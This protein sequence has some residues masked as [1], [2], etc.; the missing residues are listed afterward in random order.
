MRRSKTPKAPSNRNL[1]S[2]LAVEL[3]IKVLKN[4]R[5]LPTL[6]NLLVASP[7]DPT[8]FRQYFYEIWGSVLRDEANE[9]HTSISAI[10]C[11]RLSFAPDSTFIAGELHAYISRRGW[12]TLA[13][14]RGDD[15]VAILLFLAEC[16]D[17]VN[18]L[19]TD[20]ARRRVLTPSGAPAGHLSHVEMYRIRRAFWRFCAL[21][22]RQIAKERSG[23]G[24]T[25]HKNP[26]FVS[27][28]V[29]GRY[30]PGN[31]WLFTTG[32]WN[33]DWSRFHDLMCSKMNGWEMDELNAVRGF[34]R[35]EVNSIQLDRIQ[36]SCMLPDQALLTQRLIKDLGDLPQQSNASSSL[37]AIA[38]FSHILAMNP[39]GAQPAIR[40]LHEWS[41]H[42]RCVELLN[43]TIDH[44]I[45][46]RFD[47]D[48]ERVRQKASQEAILE[49]QKDFIKW[50]RTKDPTLYEDWMTGRLPPVDPKTGAPRASLNRVS[51]TSADWLPINGCDEIVTGGESG[52][53]VHFA[54]ISA[55]G[56]TDD[57]L[58]HDDGAVDVWIN[59]AFRTTLNKVDEE[60]S[61]TTCSTVTTSAYD[62]ICVVIGPDCYS[63]CKID[64]TEVRIYT[65]Y[66]TTEPDGSNDLEAA[67]KEA[68]PGA[69]IEAWK[70]FESNQKY[71][72]DGKEKTEWE[73]T[74]CFDFNMQ[75]RRPAQLSCVQRG[76]EEAEALEDMPACEFVPLLNFESP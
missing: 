66:I 75:L 18:M 39:G 24:Q 63:S 70:S 52:A 47:A 21:C 68:C 22:Q 58:V 32:R 42:K 7:A 36:S 5:D 51:L 50:T 57:L 6:R 53:G 20:F 8:I 61:T 30:D 26:R 54:D 2:S 33:W 38:R 17:T 49:Y 62:T 43:T 74:Q 76:V 27:S 4:I 19:V 44:R 11:H 25:I 56:H 37:P 13:S 14:Y 1:W 28:G 3:R 29:R 55:N 59:D 64:K 72:T 45:K 71:I 48:V 67:I 35:D 40:S 41:C 23:H 69:K 15:A 12:P 60:K 16:T 46:A 31:G 9:I 34:M 10:L 65:N 73:A